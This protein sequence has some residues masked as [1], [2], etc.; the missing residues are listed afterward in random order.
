MELSRLGA[1]V[2]AVDR[3]RKLIEEISSYVAEAEGFDATE[4]NL[5]A[6]RGIGKMDVAVVAVGYREVRGEVRR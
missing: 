2:L 5:L 6:S 4:P 1:E 3:S